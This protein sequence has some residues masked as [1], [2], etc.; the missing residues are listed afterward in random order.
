MNLFR[1]R[2]RNHALC[3]CQAFERMTAAFRRSLPGPEVGMLADG[4]FVG[5]TMPGVLRLY[6][7]TV[8]IL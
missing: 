3:E 8:L 4:T 2:R 1:R 5:C 6:Y 7:P